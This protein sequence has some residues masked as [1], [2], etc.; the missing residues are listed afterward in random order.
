MELCG[1][2]GGGSRGKLGHGN[3]TN[4]SSPVQIGSLT[5]WAKAR[6][7]GQFSGAVKTDGTLWMW[8]Y[9]SRGQLGQGNTTGL[10]SPVQVGTLTD[11]ADLS[12]SYNS[13]V[14]LK[15][16][17][18]I[19]GWGRG[20]AFALNGTESTDPLCSPVQIGTDTDWRVITGQAALKGEAL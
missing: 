15:T 18:T 10:S 16:D 12:G 2:G 17:N 5:T 19:W 14:G 7:L 13:T 1:H 8:G 6:A 3:T 4:Q 20:G 9:N 11:W